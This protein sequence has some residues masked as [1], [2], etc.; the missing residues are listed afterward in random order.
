MRIN[1]QYNTER[2]YNTEAKKHRAL[3]AEKLVQ[4]FFNADRKTCRNVEVKKIL[5]RKLG[6]NT[7]RKCATIQQRTNNERWIWETCYNTQG[8]F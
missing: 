7:G 5:E 3:D 4:L 6:Y 1:S 2:C 8:I